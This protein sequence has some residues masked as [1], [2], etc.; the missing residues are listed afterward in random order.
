MLDRRQP[1]F[2]PKAP[3][4]SSQLP[5]ETP[6]DWTQSRF[7]A[8]STGADSFA[9]CQGRDQTAPKDSG[10]PKSHCYPSARLHFS[11]PY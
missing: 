8:V 4:R 6:I 2:V 9:A 1:S 3:H 5:P 11:L 7:V 10:K